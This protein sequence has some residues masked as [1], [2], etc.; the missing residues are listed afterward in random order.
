MAHNGRKS[1]FFTERQRVGAGQRP[2]SEKEAHREE[3]S[4]RGCGVCASPL[5]VYGASKQTNK[6]SSGRGA[7]A[8]R[9]RQ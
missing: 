7:I 3:E 9:I 4:M 6:H 1:T 8:N 5:P 2:K